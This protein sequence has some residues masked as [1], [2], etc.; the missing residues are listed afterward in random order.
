VLVR[1]ENISLSNGS[2]NGANIVWSG[3]VA[4]AIFRGPRSSV[5]I[6]TGGER[7]N[8]EA[9]ALRDLRVGDTVELSVSTAGAWAIRPDAS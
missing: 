8:V 5:A 2:V 1:P 9:P 4:Q 6:E 3:K 7:I